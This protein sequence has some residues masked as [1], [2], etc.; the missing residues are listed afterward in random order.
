[1]IG[2]GMSVW[3]K[4]KAN[5]LTFKGATMKYKTSTRKSCFNCGQ[6]YYCTQEAGR[7]TGFCIRWRPD[8]VAAKE[9]SL[10]EKS[11]SDMVEPVRS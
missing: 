11:E 7:K 6:E 9:R 4:S 5:K 3:T 1:M 2:D 10:G 8:A